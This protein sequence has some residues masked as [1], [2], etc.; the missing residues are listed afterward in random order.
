LFLHALLIVL[1][2]VGLPAWLMRQQAETPPPLEVALVVEPPPAPPPAPAPPPKPEPL[3]KV[4]LSS[5]A[6]AEGPGKPA[7]A[8]Q[9]E[10]APE[11]PAPGPP[12]TVDKK[13][14]P[15]APRPTPPKP[16]AS[17]E[18]RPPTPPVPRSTVHPTQPAPT[19]AA[20]V[21][22]T[23]QETQTAARTPAPE[24]APTARGEQPPVPGTGKAV[25]R[26]FDVV[27]LEVPAGIEPAIYNAY[28]AAVRDKIFEQRYLLKTFRYSGGGVRLHL[29]IDRLGRLQGKA[30][31]AST[32]SPTLG[33]T[34]ENMVALAANP[35]PPPPAQFTG[36]RIY[37]RFDLILP[38]N[39]AEW[40]AMMAT[41]KPG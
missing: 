38:T 8:K 2:L 24:T 32:G 23:E 13:P 6:Q 27:G 12:A 1:F 17:A 33:Y 11:A 3:P 22:P 20:P 39:A 35:F 10:A 34:A 15:P 14:D 29:E 40:D 37:L 28:L 16:P 4:P 31:V 5:D 9:D 30:V 18:H 21:K 7:P 25:H 41:G 19:A 36:E 26:G